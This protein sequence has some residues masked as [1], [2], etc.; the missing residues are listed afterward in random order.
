[1]TEH[2]KIIDDLI[3]CA[4]RSVD[5]V[6]AVRDNLSINGHSL[7]VEDKEYDLR[8]IKKIKVVGAG[9]AAAPMA[10]AVGDVLLDRVDGGLVIVKHG[11][12]SPASDISP[13]ELICAGHPIPEAGGVLATERIMTLAGDLGREDLLVTVISGGCSALLVSPAPGISLEDK[14]AVIRAALDSGASIHQI[15]TVRKHLSSIKGGLLAQLASPARTISL[16]I[17]DVVG[18]APDTIGSGP[19][20]PD[21]TTFTEAMRVLTSFDLVSRVPSSVIERLERGAAGDHRETPTDDDPCFRNVQN[22][23]IRS[24]RHAAKAAAEAA[25]KHGFNAMIVEPPLQGL[26]RDAGSMIA[27]MARTV[28]ESGRPARRPACLVFF[29]ETT[30]NVT[31]D[32]RGGRNQEL[33]LAAAFDIDGTQGVTIATLATD[34]QDGPTDVAGAIVNSRTIQHARKRGMDPGRYLANNDSYSFFDALDGLIR[35]GNTLTN[36]ADL[37]FALI[38]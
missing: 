34:G 22:I 4:L 19:T 9:K 3:S 28:V 14:Q 6:E 37:A 25:F 16:I 18:D 26:A 23:V 20:A 17:S 35:T 1:M 27:S 33:A 30:V 2:R 31:G 38:D 8:K 29:G 24:G 7:F 11:H 21:P 15:N 10:R 12:D 13:I 36:V 32:G 5:P